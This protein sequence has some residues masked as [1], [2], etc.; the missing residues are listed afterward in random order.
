MYIRQDPTKLSLAVQS[1]WC[2]QSCTRISLMRPEWIS[3]R[4]QSIASALFSGRTPWARG[5]PEFWT[6]TEDHE[7]KLTYSY[8]VRQ[9]LEIDA[10][11]GH[12]QAQSTANSDN[13]L[14]QLGHVIW[15]TFIRIDWPW[16][17]VNEQ[18]L[19]ILL[20]FLLVEKLTKT[21]HHLPTNVQTERYNCTIA[22]I[23]SHFELEQQRDW[24]T[25][26][27]S[28]STLTKRRPLVR[29]EPHRSV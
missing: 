20:S 14:G 23:M 22:A 6:D 28:L 16:T 11:N 2:V 24:D 17:P 26:V 13:I 27:Q 4:T 25:Y 3:S 29:Q 5:H 18:V 19:S 10:S 15:N 12:S 7:W 8:H 9:F 21:A 1:K